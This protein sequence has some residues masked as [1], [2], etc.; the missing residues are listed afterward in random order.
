MNSRDKQAGISKLPIILSASLLIGLVLSYFLFPSFQQGVNHAFDVFTSK[1]EERV[2]EWVSQFGAWGPVVI[3]VGMVL[4]MFL[5]IVPNVLLIFI[6]V[7]CYGP[8][9]G[10]LL[11]WVGIFFA[12]SV[13][14][15][16][17][18]KLSPVVVHRLVTP[19]TQQKLKEFIRRYGMKSIIAFRVTSLAN[20]G[21]S[22]VAGLLNMRYRRF[23]TASMI[24]VT[25]LITVI[26]IF[27]HN[28]QIEKALVWVGAFLLLSLA[29]YIYYDKLRE[30]RR[31]SQLSRRPSTDQTTT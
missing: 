16:I 5:F 11:A 22:V 31:N 10:A 14:Y 2:T 19:A 8:V 23:I 21:L 27:G 17:G 13:G 4:Q 25:P 1:D 26:A 28:G 7:F 12:S 30:K 20:D 6:S 29:A 18:R 15:T 9:W 3:V 24:G